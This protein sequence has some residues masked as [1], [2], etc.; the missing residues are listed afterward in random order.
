MPLASSTRTMFLVHAD[1][2]LVMPPGF[3]TR[4]RDGR[5]NPFQPRSVTKTSC[6][7]FHSPVLG[8]AV[9]CTLKGQDVFSSPSLLLLMFL[10][11]CFWESY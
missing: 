1:L 8:R 11:K 9:L 7:R 5:T 4:P 2:L 6:H 3:T 10:A